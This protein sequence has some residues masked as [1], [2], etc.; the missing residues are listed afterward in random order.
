MTGSSP[1]VVVV[2]ATTADLGFIATVEADSGLKMVRIG[3]SSEAR[4]AD[5]M[6]REYPG[7]TFRP[8][9]SLAD[10]LVNYAAGAEICFDDVELDDACLTEFSR[11]VIHACRC[12]SYGETIT[13]GELAW[14]AQRPNAYRAVG[15]VMAKNRWPI[16]VPCHRVVRGD[17]GAG[18]FSA[19]RGVEFKQLLL[20]LEAKTIRQSRRERP[21]A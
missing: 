12:V 3:D 17:G 6:R 21:G 4:I 16:V 7:C 11:S 1:T 13:Y 14:A 8:N 10:Q 19:P 20:A 2:V 5:R 18:G 9:S 15:T